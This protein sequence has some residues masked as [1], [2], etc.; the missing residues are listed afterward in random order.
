MLKRIRTRTAMSMAASMSFLLFS[1]GCTYQKSHNLLPRQ[2]AGVWTTD[3][4]RYKER[5]LELSP[6]FVIVVTG[7]HDAPSVEM[8]DRVETK[9][10]GADTLLT[11]YSTD[12]SKGSHSTM[13]AQFSSANG[14]EIRFRNQPQVWTRNAEMQKHPSP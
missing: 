13:K 12:Y 3:D 4:P 6:A 10:N 1:V 9:A 14:G 7:R 11:I 2:I 8:I 5:T